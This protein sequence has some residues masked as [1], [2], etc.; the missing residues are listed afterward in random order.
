MKLAQL[1]PKLTQVG[2]IFCQIINILSKNCQR[3]VNFGQSGEISP[4][5]V[6]LKEWIDVLKLGNK[7][8]TDVQKSKFSDI[9]KHIWTSIEAS[10]WLRH[11]CLYVD[12]KHLVL[13]Q[14]DLMFWVKSNP[15]VS[16][17]C[18]NSIYWSYGP[19]DPKSH[20]F[21]GYFCKQIWSQEL[22]KIAQSGLTVLVLRRVGGD[23]AF[24][25][26]FIK[27]PI[28]TGPLE[29]SFVQCAQIS[30]NFATLAKPLVFGHLVMV[31][32]LFGR[33]FE[34]TYFFKFLS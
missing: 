13:V 27:K 20:Q 10:L 16:N 11:K 9:L 26:S 32:L 34:P 6:T 30:H 18:R 2:S 25:N 12:A 1:C 24:E 8:R 15:N 29:G 28:F 14:C 4:N 3:L 19:K 17:C 33:N 21:F 23:E 5:L 31:Y 22:S 7:T